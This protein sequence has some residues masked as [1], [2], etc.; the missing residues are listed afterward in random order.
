MIYKVIELDKKELMLLQ[1][2]P[3]D[4]K[5]AKSKLRLTE[6]IRYYGIENV[7]VSFSG[8]KDSTV[9][10]H[11]VRILYPQIPGVFSDTGLEFPELKEFVKTIEN[12]VT[13]KPNITFPK[14]VTK[15]GFPII[16]KKVSR[17]IHDL[18]NPTDKN[19]NVRNLYLTGITSKGD[20]CL[21]RKLAKKYYPLI[22]SDFRVS[23]R[24]CDVMKKAPL[25]KYE[26]ESGR[27][28]IIG[29]LA[30]EGDDREKSYLQNGCINWNKES[31]NP[32][33]FWTEQDI[34]RYIQLNNLPYAS[35]YGELKEVG[36]IL[37][38]NEEQRT[39]CIFCMFGCT[40]EKGEDR[41]F[42]RLKRTHPKLHNYCIN[43]GQYD[44]EGLWVPSND[45]LGMGKVLDEIGVDY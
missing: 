19:I 6:F 4:I 22:K 45:G 35:V 44:E 42:V 13:V 10:L 9:L 18:K 30:E 12:I 7:Y 15:Y 40:H 36:G 41:R 24:C 38:F 3:L 11:L 14:V 5:V 43:G 21:S 1:G 29:M 25:H 28:P 37:K 2:L 23:N 27:K 16:S 34:L 26:K 8:G 17:A 39:G 32:L 31:C 33:G 20:K